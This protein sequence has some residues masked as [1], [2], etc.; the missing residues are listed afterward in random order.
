MLLFSR[1]TVLM[2]FGNVTDRNK[3]GAYSI[4]TQ[5]IHTHNHTRTCFGDQE[6]TSNGLDLFLRDCVHEQNKEPFGSCAFRS[7]IYWKPQREDHAPRA[8]SLSTVQAAVFDASLIQHTSDHYSDREAFLKVQSKGEK[9]P[10][11][12]SM[13][14]SFILSFWG[15]NSP[16]RFCLITPCS[17]T[18]ISCCE[19]GGADDGVCVFIHPTQVSMMKIWAQTAVG[20]S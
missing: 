16:N 4:A 7:F 10:L 17:D 12:P 2:P 19:L 13:P 14:P 9:T 1:A 11:S 20:G 6:V 3:Q 18:C 8:D 5:L 15:L